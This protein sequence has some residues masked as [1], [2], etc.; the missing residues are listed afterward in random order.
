VRLGHAH[1]R[2][3]PGKVGDVVVFV[4]VFVFFV[5]VVVVFVVEDDRVDKGEAGIISSTGRACRTAA[6]C[7]L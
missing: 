7:G 5:V 6:L 2:R 4:F 1:A 3:E